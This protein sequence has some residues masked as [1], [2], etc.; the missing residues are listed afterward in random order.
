MSEFF[1]KIRSRMFSWGAESWNHRRRMILLTPILLF[2]GGIGSIVV[3]SALVHRGVPVG[4]D[5]VF[6]LVLI[7]V[8][9]SIGYL[10]LA[11]ID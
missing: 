10:I 6:T 4:P 1:A 11:I 5:G 3:Q 2:V 9:L 7:L 8:T